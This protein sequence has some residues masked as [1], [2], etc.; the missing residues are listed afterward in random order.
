MR[1]IAV[2]GTMTSPSG[3][4][5]AALRLA[6][7]F[8]EHGHEAVAAFLYDRE[9]I[10]GGDHPYITLAK[11]RPRTALEMWRLQRS[12]RQW[13][14]FEQPDVLI[15]FLPLASVVG[16]WTALMCGIKVRIVSHRVPRDTYTRAM[17]SLDTLSAKCG[18]Y[19]QVVAVSQSVGR[20]CA[21]YPQA[22]RSNLSVIYNGLKDFQTSELTARDARTRLGLP[23][24]APLAVAVGRL[25]RQKNYPVLL[26]GLASTDATIN[27]AIAGNG[28]D[29]AALEGLVAELAIADRVH[30][31]G[32][33]PRADIAHLLKA[34][35]IFV[36]PS[37]FEGQSNALLE[38]LHAGLPCLVSDAPEQIETVS[39]ADGTIAGAVLPMHQPAEWANALNAFALD[40]ADREAVRA[41][42]LRLAETFTFRHMMAAYLDL[43]DPDK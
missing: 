27:L 6:A 14:R 1:K 9:P 42:A 36:Q 20:S 26:R 25:D 21:A 18:A 33:L 19:T 7:G 31:L 3:A 12:L 22:L 5:I 13:L 41:T 16:C 29:R 10:E 17:R 8:A 2:L 15:S 35:D 40:F 23:I 30:L 32:S 37:L 28:M 38:A 11:S 4:P 43:I 34:A 24:D 39:E